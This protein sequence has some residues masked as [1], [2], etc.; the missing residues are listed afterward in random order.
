MMLLAR[1]ARRRFASDCVHLTLYSDLFFDRSLQVVCLLG[2][3]ELA[4]DG[5]ALGSQTFKEDVVST[6]FL[7]RD[8][9]ECNEK[10]LSAVQNPLQNFLNQ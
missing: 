3:L 5:Y 4:F 10:S 7:L 1:F 6:F 2:C 9:S 8:L